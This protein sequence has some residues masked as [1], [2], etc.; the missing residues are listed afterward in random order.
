MTSEELLKRIAE[1]ESELEAATTGEARGVVWCDLYYSVET[2]KGIRI[3]R[4]S[5]TARS[6]V[7]PQRADELLRQ[8]IEE[9]LKRGWRLYPQ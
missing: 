7:S 4:K 6:Y 8:C 2:P 9:N 3:I 1:L 5:V